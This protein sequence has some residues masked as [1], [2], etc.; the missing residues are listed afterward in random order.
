[1]SDSSRYVTVSIPRAIADKVD[2]LIGE[3]GYWPSRSAFVREASLEKIYSVERRLVGLSGSRIGTGQSL[4]GGEPRR[5]TNQG[6]SPRETAER[7][8]EHES[9]P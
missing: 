8:L 5:G 4:R 3:L 6:I 7:K 2:F 1:L 9:S